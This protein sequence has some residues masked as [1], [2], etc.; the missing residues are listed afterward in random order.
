M[1]HIIIFQRNL[2]K[3]LGGNGHLSLSRVNVCKKFAPFDLICNRRHI[4]ART[5]ISTDSSKTI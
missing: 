2:Q 4:K 3:Q 5:S 1:K